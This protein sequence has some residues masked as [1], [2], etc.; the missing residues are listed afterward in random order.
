[1]S[2]ARY[3]F[4]SPLTLLRQWR[5]RNDGAPLREVLITGYTLDLV[6]LERHCVSTAR[7]LGAR[8]TVLG[9][10]HQAVHDPVDVRHAGR[11]YQHGYAHCG[12]AFHPK[13]VILA[14]D[15]EVWAA[16]GSGNPTM[17]GWG[18]NHE[19]W[20]VLR[21]S[22]GPGP[23][24]LRDLAGWL[25]D[26]PQVVAMPSWI[27]ETL[28]HVGHT[29][30]PAET[31][32]SLP[33]LR[34]FGNLRRS[35][36]EQ[37]PATPVAS[38]RM[39][40]P[41]FDAQAAAV[42]ALI[43]RFAPDQV[44]LAVQPNL[45]QYDGRALDH[46]SAAVPRTE[47]RFLGE[48]RTRHGKLVEWTAN[49]D[50]TALVGSANLSAAAMLTTTAAGGNC[51]LVVSYSVAG[52]LLP[53]GARVGRAALVTRNTIPAEPSDARAA[54]LTVFG[55]RRL[56]D[57]IRVELATTTRQ[58][59]TI[60]TS[61]DGTPDTWIPAHVVTADASTPMTVEF[62]VPE[63]LGGA[64]RAWANVSGT[65]II[66]PVVFLTD[67]NRCLPRDERPDQPKLIRNYELDEVITDPVLASRF[68]ADFLRLLS[69]I[70]ERRAPVAPLS[71]N[72]AVKSSAVGD[73]R[74][75]IWL[76]RVERTLG[77]SL[78]NLVFP[79]VVITL[80]A[81]TATGWTVGPEADETELADDET[82]E[83]LDDL[84]TDSP[85]TSAPLVPPSQRQKWRTTMR[86]LCHAVHSEPPPPLEMRMTVARLYVDLL[87]A[88]IWGTDQTWRADLRDIIRSLS[89]SDDECRTTPSQ[90]L[91]FMS[92]LTAVCLTLLCQDANL[93]GGTEHDLIAKA[94]WNS[95][96]EWVPFAEP[97]LVENYL[98][99]PNQPYAR[100]ASHAEVTALIEL[101]TAAADD[102]HAELRAAFENEGLAVQHIDRVW[103]ADG[104]F[105]NPRRIAARIATLAGPHCV[106]LARNDRRA[107]LILRENATV[108]IAE[109]TAPRW[110]TYRLTPLGTPLSL[111]AGDEGLPS[112]R[113]THPLQP[114][115][116]HVRNLAHN[117][118][119]NLPHLMAALHAK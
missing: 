104:Q 26:L 52:S 7:A 84:A 28:E 41:F 31:D 85:T 103:V 114:V 107:S 71:K 109:S 78:T 65:R 69:Q 75:S 20:L 90:A 38:L 60:E 36:I 47:F 32:G 88:G 119:V 58:P 80:P 6:F 21:A 63:Q 100:V 66:S 111:L 117:A 82:D 96:R 98:Y 81:D 15:D 9:D 42:Q 27:A 22:R 51:E 105:H 34:V 101:A 40:A 57:L 59:I 39:T 19:L 50:T 76:D 45:S 79:G 94:A 95:A 14:G 74:W 113:C 61:P 87:A 16:I 37:L 116:D 12:G 102:P 70:K 23:V 83:I 99:L 93:H 55:A 4:H 29:I 115:P 73:D 18:H 106:V 24:A 10:A 53:D 67:T 68:S 17:S 33:R 13:L 3:E 62:R 54:A 48:D 2:E 5:D 86:R 112:T 1:M 91:S 77:P 49:G 118:Q 108:V 89:P 97:E 30:A 110:R 35:L 92:S 72:I 64:V 25:A 8:I 11:T 56:P 43:A 44:T 46:A